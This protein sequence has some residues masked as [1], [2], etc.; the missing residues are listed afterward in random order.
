MPFGS[1]YRS[2]PYRTAWWRQPPPPPPPPPPV[3]ETEG[4]DEL[5][6]FDGILP[7]WR[8][9]ALMSPPPPQQHEDT[10]PQAVLAL[11]R[12]RQ[13]SPQR[14]WVCEEQAVQRA[15]LPTETDQQLVP[16]AT[17]QQH[18][19]YKEQAVHQ[20][21]DMPT[22]TQLQVAMYAAPQQQ[23]VFQ[24][25]AVQPADMPTQTRQ[26]TVP[27][28]SPQQQLVCEDHVVQHA[29]MPTATEQVV[30]YAAPQQQATCV[31]HAAQ[32]VWQA[33]VTLLACNVRHADTDLD[34]IAQGPDRALTDLD[35]IAHGFSPSIFLPRPLCP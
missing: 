22:Q 12:R 2:E 28:A 30:S 10:L 16:C 25:Q 3:I 17:A 11:A 15:D 8:W 35:R 20:C 31:E 6:L 14:Q 34:R 21:A 7:P 32:Q 29:D 33:M 4:M 26:Q 5:E 9:P 19:H 27:H 24:E 13:L 1:R 18:V 23:V